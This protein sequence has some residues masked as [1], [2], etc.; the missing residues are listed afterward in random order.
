[1]ITKWRS[2]TSY[3]STESVLATCR[4]FGVRR[5]FFEYGGTDDSRIEAQG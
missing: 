1:M 3:P 5:S 2:G 4:T